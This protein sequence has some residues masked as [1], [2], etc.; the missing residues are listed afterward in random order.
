MAKTD[1]SSLPTPQAHQ[2]LEGDLNFKQ[3][4]MKNSENTSESLLIERNRRLADLEKVNQLE[5]KIGV[6]LRQLKAKQTSLTREIGKI[7]NIEE[8]KRNAEE[9]KVK[10]SADRIVLS[11][12]VE[13]LKAQVGVISSKYEAKNAQLNENETHNQLSSLEQKLRHH[14]S[15]NFHLKECKALPHS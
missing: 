15:N 2:E 8:V 6:E 9:M 5:S 3:K 1:L 4:E 7:G 11:T 10:N 13:S 14:E 12:Q